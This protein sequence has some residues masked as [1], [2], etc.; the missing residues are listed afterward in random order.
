M[1]PVKSP[2]PIPKP[3]PKAL[4]PQKTIINPLQAKP[5]Q[6]LNSF[7]I[8]NINPQSLSELILPEGKY[9]L[10]ADSTVPFVSFQGSGSSKIFTWGELIEIPQGQTCKVKN[11][12]FMRG[13]IV[14]NSGWDYCN[15][16]ARISVPFNIEIKYDGGGVTLWGPVFPADVRTARRAFVATSLRSNED[17]VESGIMVMGLTKKHSFPAL[18]TTP[19]FPGVQAIS[20]QTFFEV[21]PATEVRMFPLGYGS[22]VTDNN[23]N[24]MGFT[25]AATF[26]F[27]GNQWNTPPSG[28]NNI[29]VLEDTVFMYI[30]EY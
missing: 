20:Y 3:L 5:F 14:I 19:L 30:I 23:A 24:P 26:I 27:N 10:G 16:P 13:D 28:V 15:K 9:S 7:F 2:P 29:L 6:R 12:S 18:E 4:E 11:E 22:S 21:F 25:D 8:A 17:A 1:S